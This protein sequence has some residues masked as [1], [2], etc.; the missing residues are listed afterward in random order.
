MFTTLLAS[1][2]GAIGGGAAIVA[3]STQA[4]SLQFLGVE[5]LRLTRGN[6]TRMIVFMR[7]G[8]AVGIT[9]T[10]GT[11]Y[12]ANASFG[13]GT[14][15]GSNTYCVANG[16]DSQ[17]IIT[18]LPFNT[19]M[20]IR[21]FEFN[22][23]NG[24]EVYNINTATGNPLSHT[25]IVQKTFYKYNDIPIAWMTRREPYNLSTISRAFSQGYIVGSW[26]G[27]T[28]EHAWRV[29]EGDGDN[30]GGIDYTSRSKRAIADD[31]TVPT[32]WVAD[33]PV[34]ADGDPPAFLD[35]GTLAYSVWVAGPYNTGDRVRV[36]GGNP[37]TDKVYESTIDGN[38]NQPPGT[39][40]TEFAVWDGNQCWGPMSVVEHGGNQYGIYVANRSIAN[41]YSVGM[42]WSNDEF[43]T[44]ARVSGNPIIS[45]S[46]DLSAF[47]VKVHPTKVGGFWYMFIQS[48]DL[49]YIVE[50]HL[51]ALEIWRTAS[52][53][54]TSDWAGWT[55]ITTVDQL[56]DRGFGGA[57][58]ISQSWDEG[59]RFHAY[60]CTNAQIAQAGAFNTK[61]EGAAL[62]FLT[63]Y[64]VGDRITHISWSLWAAFQAD[65]VK[66]RDAF[67][68][69]RQCEIENRTWIQKRTHAGEDYFIGSAFKKKGQTNLNGAQQ[70]EPMIDSQILSTKVPT[71]GTTI[72]TENYPSWVRLGK[73]HQSQ[74]NDVLGTT[75]YPFDVTGNVNG[76]IV[77]SPR[78]ARCDSI[79]PVSGG[80]V[81][82]PNANWVLDANKNM[83][84][85]IHGRT[86]T[87]S[88]YGICGIALQFE[89]SHPS[90][91][92]FDIK[93]WGTG[94]VLYKHYRIN[95]YFNYIANNDATLFVVIGHDFDAGTLKVR[96]DYNLDV[97]YEVIHEDSFAAMN[98]PSGD[99]IIGHTAG[100][101]H[102]LDVVGAF[103]RFNGADATDEHYLYN[104]L[105][106]Y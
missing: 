63:T 91:N 19:L 82:F 25:T 3:P 43:T 84:K 21:A 60:I 69:L 72:G 7:S 71:S 102:S 29:T 61:E 20:G 37:S 56:S 86:D 55:K 32:N 87:T 41:R 46:A 105:M 2:N 57:I 89:Y 9:P 12:A 96:I 22:G 92:D 100:Q 47:Y 39:G 15:L 1:R 99:L 77:G 75:C 58:D 101:G 44:Y 90:Q 103:Q 6:G 70:C 66:E 68:S 26:L 30:L 74:I 18:D 54:T 40:W 16:T 13:A 36:I 106:G 11:T 59:G 42:I 28:H 93:V 38:T 31:P 83:F 81:T 27:T 64:P 88:V 24:T 53:P 34:N 67:I 97:P 23:T 4:T 17:Y 76:T 62:P 51:Y 50:N 80:Y 35:K 98:V 49:T 5:T 52:D 94:G 65:F 78:A 85:I 8:G 73:P 79:Q 10:D 104:N 95:S 14:N 48:Y 33:G 45:Q